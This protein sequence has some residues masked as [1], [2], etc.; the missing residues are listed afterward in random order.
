MP[1]I[2]HHDIGDRWVVVATFAVNGTATDPGAVS[3]VVRKPDGTLTT[4]PDGDPRIGNSAVGTYE[5]G[6]VGDQAGVHYVEVTGTTPAAGKE[7]FSFIVDPRWPSDLLE[8][9]ALT[10]I[11][12]VELM[13]DRVGVQGSS[14]HEENDKRWIASLINAYSVLAQTFMQRELLPITDDAEPDVVRVFEYDGDGILSLAPYEAR[15]V[16]AVVLHADRPAENQL[17]LVEGWSTASFSWYAEPRER[18]TEG[19]IIALSVPRTR[20][21]T[22]VSVAGKWGAGIVPADVKHA[23]EAECANSFWASRVRIPQNPEESAYL[24]SR[25][26]GI[27]LSSAAEGIL[28]AYA[29]RTLV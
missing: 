6:D 14:G 21:W 7:R 1:E 4:I 19:T 15:E 23:V 3:A 28:T 2:A 18:T 8:P 12:D 9:Q 20:R 11:E 10:T 5:I 27:A 13:M 29:N 17:L 26:V 25:N 24:P 22:D 16:S